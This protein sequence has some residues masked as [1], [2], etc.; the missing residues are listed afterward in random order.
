MEKKCLLK[1]MAS[2]F[3]LLALMV[4]MVQSVE[5]VAADNGSC[6]SC[7]VSSL[8][9]VVSSYQ[10]EEGDLVKT[11]DNGIE[12]I[13]KSDGSIIVN[14]YTHVFS[15]ADVE[16]MSLRTGGL[17]TLGKAIWTAIGICSAI[18]YITGHD[19]CRIVLSHLGTSIEYGKYYIV[20]GEYIPGYIPGCE[21]MHSGPC[22]QGYWR[23]E[24][25]K[26]G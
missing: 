6:A 7:E 3:L 17:V 19:L 25:R 18:D 15:D 23:Y 8:P 16:S 2:S 11:F 21:P 14:D 9:N 20:S 5:I 26:E 12:A 13:Y 22:N 4:C 10:N 24:V 1:R